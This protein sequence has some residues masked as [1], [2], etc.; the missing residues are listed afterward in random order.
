MDGPGS[1]EPELRRCVV[2][3]VA[4][5]AVRP[6]WHPGGAASVIAV[7]EVVDGG[8]VL[9]D[10]L[11]NHPEPKDPG[12]EVDVRLRVAG[13]RADVMYALEFHTQRNTHPG[14]ISIPS[15]RR[16]P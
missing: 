14:A 10:G 9:V 15:L 4:A 5:A 11:F 12:V 8:V 7:E 16:R 13:D 2:V 3:D 6:L 1:G